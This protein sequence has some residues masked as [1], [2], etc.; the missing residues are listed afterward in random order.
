ME[1]G[2]TGPTLT[3]D[4]MTALR[5]GRF[6]SG[7]FFLKASMFF[8]KP[9]DTL[10]RVADTAEKSNLRYLFEDLCLD[11][12]RRE[13][14]RDGALVRIEP[15]VFDL[16]EYL[17][18][19]CGRLVTKD[20]L[21]ASVWQGRIVSESAL[22]T[23]LSAARTSIGDSGE[24]QRLIKTVP[25]KGFRF[26]GEVREETVAVG[27]IV[28]VTPATHRSPMAD[29][30]GRREHPH[31]PL[32]DRPS[33]VVL[34]FVN[35]SGD[36]AQEYFVDGMVE[37]ITIA[38]GRLPWLF[39][40]GSASAFTY[41]NRAVDVRQIGSELGVRYA[42]KGSVRKESN[43]VRITCELSETSHGGHVWADRF[44]DELDS[45]F[46][47]QDRV[48]GHVSTV[49]A[50]ALRAEEIE[51]ARRKPTGN[52]SAYD[53]FLRALSLHRLGYAQN[54]EALKLLNKAIALDPSYS[55]AYGLAA[56]CYDLQ[57][58]FGWVPPSD[59]CLNE[60]IRL[61]RTAADMRS[62]D[63]EALWMTAHSL[64]LLA[65]ETELALALTKKAISLNPNS[66]NSWWVSGTAHYFSD[67]PQ[68]A[69]E[70]GA[71]ARRLSPVDPMA[72]NHWLSTAMAYFFAGHYQ[73]AADAAD[74]S[75]AEHTNFPPALRLKV[76][77]S[78]LLG[79]IEEGHE[80]VARLLTVN[81]D[82]TV[83][84]LKA[85][86]EPLLRINPHRLEPYLKGLRLCG[87]PEG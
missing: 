51:R 83:A 56:W 64:T 34:P 28:P 86:Y 69:L 25:R 65:G 72:Y 40:I 3:D 26:V 87:L 15:Q 22:T 71:C 85:F 48:A 4:S 47:M 75:L 14:R 76:V 60:G 81:P 43:R 31:L 67:S 37:D 82:A 21:I 80:C 38:L 66:P 58:I 20:D 33:I 12:N 61:A 54:Q 63:S 53:L 73:E 35:L 70:H 6:E 45:I 18:R 13:L 23:R 7:F 32:P 19:N 50:P 36:P 11:T 9:G 10:A 57:K 17:V 74:K 24:R 78:G 5:L 27:D 62:N 2:R 29:T 41:K 8:L 44:E 84:K 16:L 30:S 42:L 46:A 39:V 1:R 49:M 52:L 68:I 59:P 77:T 55:A 79:R